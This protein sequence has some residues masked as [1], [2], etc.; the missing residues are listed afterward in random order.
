MEQIIIGHHQ[1]RYRVHPHWGLPPSGTCPVNDCHEMVMDARGRIILLTNETRNNLIVYNKNGKILDAFGHAFPGAH[2]LS[3]HDENGTQMLYICDIERHQ[4]IKTDLNGRV[5]L[6]IGYPVD[7]GVYQRADQFLPTESVVAPNGDLYVTD[8]YGLQYVI[9]YNSKGH[10]IR[11]WGGRGNGAEQFDCAHGIAV[12]HRNG[13]ASLLI[14]SRNHNAFKRFTM[15]GAYLE[16]IA[17]PGSFVCRPVIRGDELYAA[18]FRSGS[19]TNAGSGYIT[20]LDGNN[21]VVATPGGS[22]PVYR[23][24]VLLPQEKAGAVF[25]HPHDVCVD[26][27]ENIYV[28]QWNSGRTYPIMLERV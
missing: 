4:V 14:T 8:G 6:E 1:H 20:I 13:D 26:D 5:I 10:Y 19:N 2:G 16:T 22:A 9:Q 24:G 28:C 12:D 23:D 11:H 21:R 15:D 25:V 7:S 17:L 18:V 27:D 3:I